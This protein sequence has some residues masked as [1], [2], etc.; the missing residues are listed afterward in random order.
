M[1]ATTTVPLPPAAQVNEIACLMLGGIGD[2]LA[3]L[4]TFAA[5]A[6]SYPGARITAI[7][8]RRL[9]PLLTGQR[10]IARVLGYDSS[11]RGR[12]GFIRELRAVRFDLWV[13]LHVPTFHTVSSPGKVFLRNALIMAAARTR[14]RLGFAVPVMRPLLTHPVPVP[15]DAHQA[16]TNIVDITLDLLPG[17]A[18]RPRTKQLTLAPA[19]LA[20]AAARLPGGDAPV[21]A[22]F[23]GGRQSASHWP[24]PHAVSFARRIL[25][26]FA[27][28]RLVLIGDLHEREMADTLLAS[29]P[30]AYRAR[31][32]DLIGQAGLTQTAALLSLCRGAICTDSGPMHLADAVGVPLV[33]LF[34]RKNHLPVWAPVSPDAIVISRPVDC[35]PCFRA[36]CPIHNHCMELIT[37]DEVLAAVRSLNRTGVP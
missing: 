11:L 33:A 21:F 1:N 2:I 31:I 17:N 8:R 34:S 14:H 36:E 9:T 15:P 37:P 27:G 35:G 24:V 6:R 20:W 28:A 26:E 5:L 25:D 16:Q 22:Y 19:D 13:D 18:T 7:T 29:L 12:L 4:P 32:H 23:F 10:E 3:T 30:P